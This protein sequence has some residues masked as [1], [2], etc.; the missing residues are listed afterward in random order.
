MGRS[1][2]ISTVERSNLTAVAYFGSGC[3]I[4]LHQHDRLLEFVAGP[5]CPVIEVAAWL[6]LLDKLARIKNSVVGLKTTGDDSLASA[7]PCLDDA[8]RNGRCSFPQ[9]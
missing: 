3:D 5:Q 7:P 9:E 1:A 8:R 6:T 4:G 2:A